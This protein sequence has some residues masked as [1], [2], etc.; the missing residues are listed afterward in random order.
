MTARLYDKP[1]F[2]DEQLV[3]VATPFFPH[4]L[5]KGYNS[6]HINVVKTVNGVKIK[7]LKHL[8]E[9][10]RDINSDY[11]EFGY[12]SREAETQVFPVKEMVT[13][14]EKILTDNGIRS[15]GSAELLTV[16]ND[17]TAH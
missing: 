15:Q 4:K 12:D 7:N 2:K 3:V 9:V 17:K 10:L 5:A 16:W 11:V 13:E 8:V 6:T 1:A 14:T